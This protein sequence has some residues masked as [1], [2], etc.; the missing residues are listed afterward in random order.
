[1]SGDYDHTDQV[2]HGCFLRHCS[3]APSEFT[4]NNN[5]RNE[6]DIVQLHNFLMITCGVHFYIKNNAMLP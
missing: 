2:S 4:L 1:M 3:N 5:Q 6:Y